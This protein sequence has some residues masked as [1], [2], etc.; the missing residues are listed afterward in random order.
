MY[1]RQAYGGS[2]TLEFQEDGDFVL[3]VSPP[4]VLSTTTYGFWELNQ[5]MMSLTPQGMPFAWEFD[6]ALINGALSLRGA[7][8]EYDFDGD[9]APDDATLDMLLAK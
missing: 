1:K 6:A 8:V 5:D 7:S 3:V 9:Y 2:A 4:G